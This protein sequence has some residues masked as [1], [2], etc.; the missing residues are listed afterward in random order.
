MTIA[1]LNRGFRPFFLGASVFAIIGMTTWMAVLL[2]S[3]PIELHNVTAFQWHAHEMIFGYA[4]AVI[5]GFLLTAAWNWTGR[6]TTDGLPLA[7]LFA[8]WVVARI[9]M[10]GGT[11]LITW[12]TA[13]DLAFMAGLG[14]AIA[15]PVIKT[16]QWRQA[17]I[18]LMLLLLA[19]TRLLF[20]LGAIGV[21]DDGARIGV[22]GALYLVLGMVLFMGRR[23]IPFFTERGVGYETVP[24]NDRW[25]DIAT[26]VIYPL[27]AI[28]EVLLPYHVAGALLA[29][30]LLL[31]NTHRVLGW[32]TAGIWH[33]PLLWGLF[34]AVVMI[35]LGF[36]MRAL[37]PVTTVPA[38]LPV[39]AY[40][41]G[42]IG[43]ITVSMMARVTLG[44]TGRN[45]HRAPPVMSLLLAG[46]LLATTGRVFMPL[47]DPAHFSFWILAA[48]GAW[49]ASF[50]L[51]LVVFGPMLVQRRAD[52][53]PKPGSK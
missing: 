22:H 11:T 45:V 24:R 28:S 37:M 32:H 17:P 33:R 53:K 41:V 36:M 21:V 49:I 26:L 47:I 51:F 18:L 4:M 38:L 40:A 7:L 6:R 29:A 8:L 15:R 31:L 1:F 16:R 25:N 35:N 48:A 42:G 23:V 14:I 34:I 27:F 30:L 46:M 43:I 52:E 19:S 39:H 5:A 10:F 44:H 12:A 2:F 9:L 3:F 50:L 20:A 13:A